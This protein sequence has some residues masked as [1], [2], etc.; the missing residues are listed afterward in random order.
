MKASKYA[1]LHL[2]LLGAL[3]AITGGNVIPK[4]YEPVAALS[5]AAI[6]ALLPSAGKKAPAKRTAKAEA[7]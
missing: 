5:L 4:Q 7:Q 6:N 1:I 2:A 3:G